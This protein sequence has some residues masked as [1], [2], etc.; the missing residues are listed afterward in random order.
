MVDVFGSVVRTRLKW[1]AFH[2]VLLDWSG[3]NQMRSCGQGFR[4]RFPEKP[5]DN[6]YL[7]RREMVDRAALP[8]ALAWVLMA[9][10]GLGGWLTVNAV[11]TQLPAFVDT[12]P[13]GWSL[14]SYM[15]VLVQLGNLGPLAFRWSP[16]R[17]ETVVMGAMCLN[18]VVL[19]PIAFLYDS[20][21]PV[22]GHLTSLPLFV[23][24][25]LL[26][27]GC[28]THSVLCWPCLYYYRPD[29]LVPFLLGEGLSNLL[30]GL[31]SLARGPVLV[32][33]CAS[34]TPEPARYNYSAT[35]FFIV[36]F[37]LMC[38]S[39]S[40]FY[41]LTKFRDSDESDVDLPAISI[42]SGPDLSRFSWE[43]RLFLPLMLAI[44]TA[45]SNGALPSVQS[46]SSRPYGR[47]AYGLS[48]NLSYLVNPGAC[49]LAYFVPLTSALFFLPS[50][51]LSFFFIAYVIT[52]ALLSP[53]PPLRD[54]P[55][56]IV[57]NVSYCLASIAGKIGGG[58]FDGLHS[59]FVFKKTRN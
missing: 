30:P 29:S 35:V 57:L 44:L 55:Y 34:S 52:A 14:A 25:F 53:S 37:V 59:H 6:K 58:R 47:L 28:C 17:R 12:A 43:T 19:F 11:Y 56:G 23:G 39:T 27:L 50:L 24:F 42:E 8:K 48:V 21:V 4:S 41:V 45:F 49:L 1:I 51:F 3:T 7:R 13:E 10:F 33:S 54:S 46:F 38:L 15:A 18:S 20:T 22:K 5:Q 2:L 16:F 32:S 26:S 36:I 9:G 40:A 31:L